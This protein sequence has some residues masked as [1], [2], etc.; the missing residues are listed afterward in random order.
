MQYVIERGTRLIPESS[1][2]PIFQRSIDAFYEGQI[3]EGRYACLQLLNEP[4]L[5]EQVRE[6]T[7]RNQSFYA[8]PLTE[9]APGCSWHELAIAAGEYQRR[10]D[11]SPVWLPDR[12]LVLIGDP[13]AGAELVTL[14]DEHHVVAREQLG[15]ET[16]ESASFAQIRPFFTDRLRAAVIMRPGE[17]SGH[18]LVGIVE[19]GA[20]AWRHLSRFG[21]RAGDF[22]RGWS[23]V[24]TE[25]GLRLVAWWE[26]T[27]IFRFD[28]ASN[29]FARVA[30]R[31][32]PHSAERFAGGSQGVAVP[33]G[34]LFLVNE[35]VSFDEAPLVFTRF[36]RLDERFQ[37]D[38]ISPQ[39]FVSNR[40]RD[41]ASGLARRENRLV[42]GFNSGDEQALL[43][44]LDVESALAMLEPVA[45][46]GGRN[47][48]AA[49][50]A[51]R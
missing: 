18:R 7:F 43:A 45:A 14:D 24:V 12:L 15:D 10:R 46:P 48:A 37:I 34:Q 36:V 25:H 2:M 3:I 9:L 4:A 44:T 40:G 29:S 49:A 50:Q 39:F 32:A 6:Q 47:S 20:G 27:E 31:M 35:R 41:A 51:K 38:A 8:Q 22:A 21:P 28:E 17:E 11:P 23:P 30:L 1:W 42:A 26:P 13:I 16:G 19:A 5:P 33:G